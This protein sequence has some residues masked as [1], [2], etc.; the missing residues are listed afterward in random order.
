VLSDSNTYVL[1]PRQPF[2]SAPN[3][4]VVIGQGG[5]NCT[6]IAGSRSAALLKAEHKG[7]GMRMRYV[8]CAREYDSTPRET[9]SYFPPPTTVIITYYQFFT[10]RFFFLRFFYN[11]YFTPYV[12]TS[13][14]RVACFRVYDPI[15]EHFRRHGPLKLRA[16]THCSAIIISFGKTYIYYII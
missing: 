16:K 12:Y 7:R 10:R 6:W 2:D 3:D 9:Y 15:T 1:C 4:S 5:A 8:L 13:C 11:R 14:G